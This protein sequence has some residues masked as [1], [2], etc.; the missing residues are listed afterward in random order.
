MLGEELGDDCCIA[1]EFPQRS[2]TVSKVADQAAIADRVTSAARMPDNDTT[3]VC[4][5]PFS[6]GDP[7]RTEETG[8]GTANAR[9]K[10]GSLSRILD[11]VQPV[12]STKARAIQIISD[13]VSATMYESLSCTY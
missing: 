6:G 12:V 13:S 8:S 10:S 11:C 7:N 1:L 3:S 5:A 4:G 9:M 2:V